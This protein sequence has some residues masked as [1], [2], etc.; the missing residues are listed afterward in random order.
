MAKRRPPKIDPTQNVKDLS[1]ADSKRQDD[2]RAE[3]EKLS[4]L[5]AEHVKELAAVRGEYERVLH[6]LENAAFL[7]TEAEIKLRMH[8][9]ETNFATELHRAEARVTEKVD[10]LT[11][12]VTQLELGA[13]GSGGKEQGIK[14]SGNLV[15]AVVLVLSA[16]PTILSIFNRATQQAQS[17]PQI[18]YTPAPPGTLVPSSPKP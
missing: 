18:I 4:T 15:V 16:L 6:R 9:L 3:A 7:K 17:P 13:S 11:L 1:T 2:L 8:E 14:L 10:P 12:R 5:R